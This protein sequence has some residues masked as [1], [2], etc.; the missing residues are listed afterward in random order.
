[1]HHPKRRL[2]NTEGNAEEQPTNESGCQHEGR[3]YKGLVRC[4]PTTSSV[5]IVLRVHAERQFMY[6]LPHVVDF[7]FKSSFA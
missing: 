2:G 1:M 5:A 6:S 3:L 4:C 7:L